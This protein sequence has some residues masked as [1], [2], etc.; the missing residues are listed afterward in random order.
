MGWLG[1]EHLH[2]TLH[3]LAVADV[4]SKKTRS[5]VNRSFSV[6]DERSRGMCGAYE[7]DHQA[8]LYYTAACEAAS[9]HISF[10]LEP[11]C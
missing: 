3:Y 10:L 5:Q 8:L 11:I 1:H 2:T 9:R 4:R 6:F 7:T